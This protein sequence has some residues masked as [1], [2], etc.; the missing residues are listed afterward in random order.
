MRRSVQ[1]DEAAPPAGPYAQG[2]I[3]GDLLFTAGQGPFDAA[4]QRVGETFE[5]QVDATLDNLEAVARAAGTSLDRA[6][7]LGV[8]IRDREDFSVL[9][10]VLERRLGG[11]P[12]PVRTT[13]PAALHGFDVEIDAIFALPSAG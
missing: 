11:D 4:G 2:Q 8:F 9:N 10:A 13:V 7:R 1:T 3:V 12:L 5:E 6:V